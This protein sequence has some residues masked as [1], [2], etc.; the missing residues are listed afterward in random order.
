[1][2]VA[3]LMLGTIVVPRTE[4]P[5]A[6]SRLTE[7]E[8]FHKI[9]TQNDTVTPEIDDLLLKAQKLYQSIDE[10]VKGLQIPARVGIMEVLFKGLVIKRNQYQ[11]DEIAS[12]ISDLEKKSGSIIDNPAKLLE[13]HANTKRSLEEYTSLRDTLEVVKKMNVNIGDLGQ[14]KYFYTNLFVI[15][16]SDYAEISRSLEGITIFKYDLDNKLK[17]AI[18]IFTD[19]YESERILKVLR[20]FNTNPFVI[21][22]GIP[23]NPSQAYGLVVSKIAELT[24]KEKK[25][26]KE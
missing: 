23:Q 24:A 5:E 20:S 9:E 19:V 18:I 15:N 3:D 6:I 13:D 21:P 22:Q 7:F 2:V 14:M 4:S 26:S 10:V 16:S 25:I 12:M 8:W 17:T 1:M 11:L